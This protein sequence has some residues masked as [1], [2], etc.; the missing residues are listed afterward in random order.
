MSDRGLKIVSAV[1]V[2]AAL[3]VLAKA[4]E[5]RLDRGWPIEWW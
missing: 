5:Y 3:G 2:I 4:I 1:L